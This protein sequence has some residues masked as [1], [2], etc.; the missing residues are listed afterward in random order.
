MA[1]HHAQFFAQELEAAGDQFGLLQVE[2]FGHGFGEATGCFWCRRGARLATG[3]PSTPFGEG[4]LVAASCG[5]RVSAQVAEPPAPLAAELPRG[6]KPEGLD[7][8]GLH[9]YLPFGEG[10]SAGSRPEGLKT[11]RG[12]GRLAGLEPVTP[13]ITTRC[14][15]QLSYSRHHWAGASARPTAAQTI[16]RVEASGN[17]LSGATG[18][19]RLRELPFRPDFS[20][21]NPAFAP[22]QERSI[23]TSSAA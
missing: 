4:G 7:F 10:Q 11:R 23:W 2:V 9:D 21:S 17:P 16:V 8:R 20:Q 18:L 1:G 12:E 6:V 19:Y 22:T 5:D 3:R 14:S 13:G 15:N